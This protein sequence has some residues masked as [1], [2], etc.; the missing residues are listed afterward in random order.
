MDKCP[1]DCSTSPSGDN[2]GSGESSVPSVPWPPTSSSSGSRAASRS[3]SRKGSKSSR[4]ACNST[5]SDVMKLAASLAA[6]QT[7]IHLCDDAGAVEKCDAQLPETPT[8]A[9]DCE[10]AG[11]G[12]AGCVPSSLSGQDAA[13][14]EPLTR[15]VDSPGPCEQLLDTKETLPQLTLPPPAKPSR[16]RR[17]SKKWRDASKKV[18]I[19]SCGPDDPI[20][21]A[22]ANKATK[23][24]GINL[25][26]V[27]DVKCEGTGKTSSARVRRSKVRHNVREALSETM[28]SKPAQFLCCLRRQSDSVESLEELPRTSLS[29]AKALLDTPSPPALPSDMELKTS[30][31]PPPPLP[32]GSNLNAVK[33]T[34]PSCSFAAHSTADCRGYCC[35]RCHNVSVGKRY[36]SSVE[37]HNT[38]CERIWA[39]SSDADTAPLFV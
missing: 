6:G 34:N 3:S 37:P 19:E 11:A 2:G 16:L 28:Y 27:E 25:G 20:D 10:E 32:S 21:K 1:S 26:F 33:C 23:E 31:P 9:A 7:S 4:R 12:A 39:F 14:V 17:I 35:K 15:S 38:K 5:T 36:V 30:A 22:P 13:A 29:S 18:E 24:S 8:A